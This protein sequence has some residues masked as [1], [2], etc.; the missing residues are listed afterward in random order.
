MAK[1]KY[2]FIKELLEDK[3][4]NQ[5]QRERIFELASKEIS[6]E[7]SLEERVQK[8]EE[9]IFNQRAEPILSKLEGTIAREKGTAPPKNAPHKPRD[10]ANFLMEFKRDDSGLKE[11]VHEPNEEIDLSKVLKNAKSSPYLSYDFFKRPSNYSVNFGAKEGTKELIKSFEDI[12][13]PFWKETKIF[14]FGTNGSVDYTK[15]GKEFKKNYRIGSERDGYS[16]LKSML[17]DDCKKHLHSDVNIHFLPDERSFN[18]R[19]HFFTWIPFL[20]KG[21]QRILTDCKQERTNQNRDNQTVEFELIRNTDDRTR[22]L[23]I[24]DVGSIGQTPPE[25]FLEQ[26]QR[27]SK[28]FNKT[29]RSLCDWSVEFYFE[30]ED[31]SYRVNLLTPIEKYSKDNVIVEIKTKPKGFTHLL[32][33]YDAD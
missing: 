14:P 22:T 8:I 28:M 16:H 9:I 1:N 24:I 27:G 25:L 15:E 23:S 17:E 30:Q 4:I 29:F 3:K 21:I 12:G 20:R 26:K 5:N 6:I 31:K 32:T 10:T 2:D 11:L 33:F 18:L 7:G 19:A 13:I